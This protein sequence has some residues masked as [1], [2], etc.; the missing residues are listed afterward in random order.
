[1]K[2]LWFTGYVTD[3]G[4]SDLGS[5]PDGIT[6]SFFLSCTIFYGLFIALG[7]HRNSTN[8]M[9]IIYDFLLH[10]LVLFIF[11]TGIQGILPDRLESKTAIFN[12]K[13]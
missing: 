9:H 12:K 3:Y 7:L 2:L 10:L 11:K 4:S 1:M 6:F 5:Y 8:D 13:K